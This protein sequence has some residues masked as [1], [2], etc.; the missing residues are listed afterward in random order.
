[1]STLTN[2][3]VIIY[4]SLGIALVGLLPVASTG[5]QSWMLLGTP[6]KDKFKQLKNKNVR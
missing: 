6:E 4:G 2:K 3:L 5:W 1:M